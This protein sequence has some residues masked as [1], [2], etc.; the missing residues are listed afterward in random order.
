MISRHERNI[1]DLGDVE[2]NRKTEKKTNKK[3]ITIYCT[4]NLFLLLKQM[5]L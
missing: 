1:F 2:K 4:K 3:K 5:N